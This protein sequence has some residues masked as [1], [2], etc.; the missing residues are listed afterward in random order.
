VSW[1]YRYAWLSARRRANNAQGSVEF[2][3]HRA[4][5]QAEAYRKLA[6]HV[7]EEQLRRKESMG[8]LVPAPP[9]VDALG[10]RDRRN[11]LLLTDENTRL[12]EALEDAQRRAVELEKQLERNPS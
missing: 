12:R 11:L 8:D 3:K 5:E 2:W 4:S 6:A 7:D 9:A 1:R 10:T